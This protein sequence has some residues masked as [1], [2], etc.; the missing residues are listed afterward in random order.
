[1]FSLGHMLWVVICALLIAG[2]LGLCLRLRP[3]L[4]RVLKVCLGLG[5]ISEVV[6]VFCVV[7][8]LPM[9][10]P[11]VSGGELVYQQTGRFAPYM[12]MEHLPLELCSL[13]LLFMALAVFS[14]P[15]KWR[16]RLL[17]FMYFSCILGGGM[18]ILFA[19]IAPEHPTTASFFCSLRPWQ[20]FPYHAMLV[21]LGIW[22]GI[23][24]ESGI[25]FAHFPVGVAGIVLLDAATFYLN[26]VFSLPVYRGGE[27]IGVSY[28]VNYFSSYWNPLG[29][30]VTE[31]WQ[32]MVYL[33]I[34]GVLAIGLI[35][36]TFLPLRRRERSAPPA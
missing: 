34:R 25:T 28:A 33:L 14:R 19:A 17:A 36:L 26:S 16:T 20:Y 27:V 9:V 15:G 7:Q 22:L 1:M 29:I 35:F 24:R 21:T 30:E 13:Q 11:A 4:D 12:E 18:G 23:S 3:S 8:L 10:E 2:G 31:K 32:W 6:K 5:V